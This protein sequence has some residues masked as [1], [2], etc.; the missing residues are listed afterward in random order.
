LGVGD[1]L[2]GL[3][4]CI[5]YVGLRLRSDLLD[6]GFDLCFA[7]QES[8]VSIS[9]CLT[10]NVIVELDEGDRPF[11]GVLNANCIYAVR[12]LLDGLRVLPEGLLLML[13]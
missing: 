8:C 4:L 6:F 10:E 9:Q 3:G 1:D 11:E 7:V 5:G 13:P 2:L 12:L